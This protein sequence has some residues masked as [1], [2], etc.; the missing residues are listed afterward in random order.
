[1]KTPLEELRDGRKKLRVLLRDLSREEFHKLATILADYLSQDLPDD[2]LLLLL[3]SG[4]GLSL[5][6][7]RFLQEAENPKPNR[8][9]TRKV[10]DG[11]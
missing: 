10:D 7:E 11:S 6:Y 3:F 4:Y 1:M 9:R 5:F 2:L 8:T